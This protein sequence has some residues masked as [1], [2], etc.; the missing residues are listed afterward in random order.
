MD[1]ISDIARTIQAAVA[2]VFFLAAIGSFLG[3]LAGR[4]NRIVDRA[5]RI[6][7]LH[8]ASSGVEHDRHVFELR[9]L[10]RR[11]RIVSHSI[12]LSVASALAICLVIGALFVAELA[13]YA[14]AKLVSVIFIVALILLVASLVYFLIEVRMAIRTIRVREA[15][16]EHG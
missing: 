1:S 4:L 14:F 11:M 13:S 3:V 6:E 15:L 5:R 9:I 10:D 16:L 8:S 12:L 2:P 7:D